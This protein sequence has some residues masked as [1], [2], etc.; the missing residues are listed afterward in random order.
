MYSALDINGRL[1]C[2]L[3][4]NDFMTPYQAVK[5]SNMAVTLSNRIVKFTIFY[6]NI[7][8]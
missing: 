7:V 1:N 2:R 4:G 8:Y 6:V 3:T 5:Q